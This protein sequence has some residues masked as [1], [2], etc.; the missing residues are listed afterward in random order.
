MILRRSIGDPDSMAGLRRLCA[1]WISLRCMSNQ[2]VIDYLSCR[3]EDGSIA[4]E[5]NTSAIRGVTA[6][7][8]K[9]DD[10]RFKA[11]E[12]SLSEAAKKLLKSIETLRL[13]PYDD[14]TSKDITKWV[15]GATIGYGHLISK[16]DWDKYKA[17][18]TVVD[19][20]LL[21]DADSKPFVSLV[22]KAITV[23]L[24]QREFD[25]L[26]I[27]A[28]NIGP[29]GFPAS[30]VVKLVNDPKAKTAY[31]DLESAWKAWNKSQGK[32]MKGLNNRRQCEWDIYTKGVYNR[33]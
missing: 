5:H 3:I 25:A 23:K 6:F 10:P 7:V 26:V 12:L 11:S 16:A 20:D 2:D 9:T 33:W 14:Q 4:L 27:L 1:S 30:S 28:Y 15:Q 22:R 8:G 29:N 21:F 19:A 13:M 18:I 31:K 32:E 24:M 17:G